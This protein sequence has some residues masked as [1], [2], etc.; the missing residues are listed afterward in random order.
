MVYYYSGPQASS[1]TSRHTW[2]GHGR[3]LPKG[4]KFS[5]L[6]FFCTHGPMAIVRSA[7]RLG[8]DRTAR[9]R[10]VCKKHQLAEFLPSH[11]EGR[12]KERVF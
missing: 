3:I 4:Y 11:R 9:A 2:P 6:M 7:A 8:A 1:S 12:E 5:E 10:C